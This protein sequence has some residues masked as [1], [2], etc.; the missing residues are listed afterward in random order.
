MKYGCGRPRPISAVAVSAVLL[1]IGFL[2]PVPGRADDPYARSRDYDLQNVRT[3]L[4]LSAEQKTIRGEVNHSVSMLR[5]DVSQLRFDSVDLEIQDVRVDG[6]PAKYVTNPTEVIVSLS[7]PAKRGERHEIFIRY[8]GAPKKGLYFIYPDKN[9]PQRPHE[10]WSQGES[11][12]THYYIPIY[13]YPNDRTTSE[14]ILT[15][16]AAWKTISNGRLVGVKDEADGTRTWDWKQSEPLSTYLIS[17]V[18]GEF[19]EQQD[20]WRGMPVRYVVPRGEEEKIP[21]TFARTKEM[22][23]AFSDRLDVRYPWAQ[24]AQTSVDD[25]VVGGM[26]NTSATTLTSEGLVHPRLASEERDGSDGL[27]SHELAHQWFGDLVTCKDWGNIWLNEGFATYFEH[28]W[29]EKHYGVDDAEYEFWKNQASWFA[30]KHLFSVPIV[31]HDYTDMIEFEGNIYGKGGMVLRMLREKLGDDNFFHGLH[32]YLDANRGRNVVTAD[33]QKAI[34]EETS[35]NVDKFFHQWVYRAGAPQFEVS[36][37]YDDAAHQVKLEV[38]QAQ[39]VERLVGIFDVPIVV[40]IATAD[41]RKM[42]TIEVNEPAQT[43]TFP[44]ASAPLMVIFD[45]GDRIL[46]SLEFKR[47]AASLIFQLQNGETVPDRADAAVALGKIKDNAD[48]AAALG[49][50]ARHDRFWGVRVEALKALG[51]IGSPEAEKEVLAAVRDDKPW[52]REVAVAQLG[53]FKDDSPLAAKLTEIAEKDKAYRVRGAALKSLAE[54]KSPGAFDILSAAVKL[55]S[56]DE[57]IREAALHGLGTLG[58]DRAVP[59]LLEW[60]AI[61]KPLETRGAAITALAGLDKSNKEITKAL[62]SYLGEPYFNIKFTA[63]FA[64]GSRGDQDAIGPLEALLKS[65]ELSIGA[66]PYI[67]SQIAALKAQ[68]GDKSAKSPHESPADVTAAAT[69]GSNASVASALQKIESEMDEVNARLSKIESQ[70]NGGTNK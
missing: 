13:D 35:I 11:E 60:A 69:A 63:L 62:V 17:L 33:L 52:V 10:I 39:K 4:W 30:Q 3:H 29:N 32:H 16:P 51:K 58:D 12:D 65:G 49:E 54:L 9:Y 40:E 19:V 37:A 28:Y 24:Y 55:E 41:G 21:S 48:A 2:F 43:F 66:A 68:S 36:Y 14:M 1:A 7:H 44:A 70:L 57:T 64:L 18:A 67:E 46:K 59:V 53:K 5:D 25:F 20:T 26:E 56:P 45:K 15:V 38:K 23:D 31:T 50:A 8:T 42:Q 27:D 6:K 22:L 34:E 47:S 61:G